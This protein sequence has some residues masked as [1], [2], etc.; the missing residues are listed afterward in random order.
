MGMAKA[1]NI[2]ICFNHDPGH[3]FFFPVLKQ[4][5]VDPSWTAMNQQ[6]V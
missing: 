5:F 3:A 1:H 6:Q 4:I 2:C